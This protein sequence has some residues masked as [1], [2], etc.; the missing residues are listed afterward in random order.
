MSKRLAIWKA[1][2]LL[3]PTER[4]AAS[5]FSLVAG[6]RISFD[7]FDDGWK[8]FLRLNEV[9]EAFSAMNPSSKVQKEAARAA[10]IRLYSPTLDAAQNTYVHQTFNAADIQLLKEVASGPVDGYRLIKAIEKFEHK[11]SG[12]AAHY[13][14]DQFQNL[15]WSDDPRQQQAAEEI[16]CPFDSY[17]T[18]RGYI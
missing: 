5:P 17:L 15:L 4:V 2:H 13:I 18:P 9:E 6:A 12:L 3:G 10:L 1:L 16:H 14:N 11:P 7:R 8:Q